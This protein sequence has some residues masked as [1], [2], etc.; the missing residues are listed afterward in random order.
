MLLGFPPEPE[1]TADVALSGP[2]EENEPPEVPFVMGLARY[3]DGKWEFPARLE[4]IPTTDEAIAQ[5]LP[6]QGIAAVGDRLYVYNN[7]GVYMGPQKPWKLVVE[8]DTTIS[9]WF[10]AIGP[11][12][13]G[14]SLE[15]FREVLDNPAGGHLYAERAEFNPAG[16]KVEFKAIAGDPAAQERFDRLRYGP[17][18]RHRR[19][20]PGLCRAAGPGRRVAAGGVAEDPRPRPRPVG[21]RRPEDERVPLAH[22]PPHLRDALCH[23]DLHPRRTHPPGPRETESLPQHQPTAPLSNLTMP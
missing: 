22:R 20:L 18:G 4:G 15:I 13:D 8:R 7:K 14:K 11:A 5:P 12:P 3:A 17:N 1:T 9:A 21:G 23:L 16:G 6:I 2:G 10:E 19:F